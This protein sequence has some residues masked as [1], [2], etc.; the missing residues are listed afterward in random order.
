MVRLESESA[1]LEAQRNEA[2]RDVTRRS[3]LRGED[4]LALASF[5]EYLSR[6]ESILSRQK[7][8]LATKIATQRTE[9]VEAERNVK[10]LGRLKDRKLQEWKSASDRELDDLAADSH[11]AR[12]SSQRAAG[13]RTRNL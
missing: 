1:S 5:K 12:L 6:R 2:E 11:L 4:L 8:E 7:T 13:L 10:L 3:D 9:V